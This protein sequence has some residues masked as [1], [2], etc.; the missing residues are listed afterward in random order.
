MQLK[1]I[2]HRNVRNKTLYSMKSIDHVIFQIGNLFSYCYDW[3][4]ETRG[5]PYKSEP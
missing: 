3:S 2:K 1:I 4:K 5:D